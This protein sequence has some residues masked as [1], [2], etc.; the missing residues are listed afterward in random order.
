MDVSVC[1]G[2]C[3]AG[4][5]VEWGGTGAVG[6][7]LG[8]GDGGIVLVGAAERVAVCGGVAGDVWVVAFGVA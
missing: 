5:L 3:E 7:G 4:V 8:G 6:G 2:F 1:L